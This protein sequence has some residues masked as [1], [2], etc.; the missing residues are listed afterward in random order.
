MLVEHSFY[1]SKVKCTCIR[2]FIFMLLQMGWVET[3][4]KMNLST[5]VTKYT[6][7]LISTLHIS[8][9]CILHPNLWCI[10]VLVNIVQ[11]YM[12]TIYIKMFFLFRPDNRKY[13]LILH[14]LYSLTE[15]VLKKSPNDIFVYLYIN[16]TNN[17]KVLGPIL[18]SLVPP[19]RSLVVLSC[20][21]CF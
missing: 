10:K 18:R 9:R 7:I 13:K 15:G 17:I 11:Y 5:L 19:Q 20:P 8:Q 6:D 16:H 1:L 12:S 4:F 14:Y 2:I 3:I 21:Q